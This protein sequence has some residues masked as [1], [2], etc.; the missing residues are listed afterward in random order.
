MALASAAGI[1]G[2]FG[3]L[4]VGAAELVAIGI[5]AMPA[6]GLRTAVLLAFTAGHVAGKSLWYA[7]GTLESTIRQPR[8]RVWIDRARALSAQHPAMG[9][10]VLAGGA[11][12]SLPPF[13]LV[14]IWA[15]LVRVPVW[16]FVMVSFG[17]RLI[18]FGALAAF[19]ALLRFV[20]T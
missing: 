11:T 10:A 19:P 18:R 1:G 14:A 7:V 9:L 5:G 17:G 15:G 6:G 3:L 8:L 12:L 13:H 4:P 2:L 16:V 20:L